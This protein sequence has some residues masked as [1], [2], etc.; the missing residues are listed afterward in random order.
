MKTIGLLGGMSWESTQSYYQAINRGV[1]ARLGGLHSAK[2]CLYSV[3]FAE[4]ETLQHQGDWDATAVIL[5]DAAKAVERGGADLLLICTNTMH[6]VAPQ[7][8]AQLSISLLHI[9]DA[10]A[11]QLQAAGISKVGLLGT[12]FTMEQDFYKGRLT[13]QFG[14]EVLVPDEQERG[15]VHRV[16]Y[17]ELCRGEI[18]PESRQ[19]YLNIIDSLHRQGAQAVILGCTEI[20]LLVQQSHTSVPLFDTTAIHAEAAVAAALAE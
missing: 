20:A 8:A 12:R 10:T 3:D 15:E 17:D 18:K 14:I 9:A 5:A 1:K 11:A 16:I 13:E 19:R 7:I 6:K 2:I 4:I